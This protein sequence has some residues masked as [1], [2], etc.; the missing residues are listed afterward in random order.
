M[1]PPGAIEAAVAPVQ[2]G[3]SMSAPSAQQD[4]VSRV[5][6]ALDGAPAS[7]DELEP[8][9]LRFEG[10]TLDAGG[11]T[12]R[13]VSGEEIALTRAEFA[14]LLALVRQPGR[15]LSRDE[16]S[17]AAVG[18]GTEPEDRSVDVLVSRLRR[19]IES[20]PKTPRIILTVPGGGYKLGVRSQS[21]ATPPPLALDASQVAASVIA[22]A[23]P[24]AG[25]GWEGRSPA[26]APPELPVPHGR[27]FRMTRTVAAATTLAVLGSIAGLVIA[28]RSTGPTM[29]DTAASA[30]AQKFDP[31][32][33]PLVTDLV[34]AQLSAYAHQPNAKAIALSREG[35][36]ISAG[37]ADDDAARNEAL[38]RCRERDKGGFCRIYAVGE[39]VVWP[40]SSLPLPLPADIRA[41]SPAMPAVTMESVSKTWQTIWHTAP[42]TVA[43]EYL[44]GKGHKALAVALTSSYWSQNRS[45]REEAVRIAI[46]RCSDLARAPCLLISVDGLWTVEMPRSYGLAAPFTLA[47]ESQMSDTERQRVA[48]A[49]NRS[50]WVRRSRF[51]VKW[52]RRMSFRTRM[53]N[54][55]SI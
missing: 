48:Q 46:E 55:I 9:L 31:A 53:E 2:P 43:T 17:H 12:L 22:G 27:S 38:E 13:N 39:D 45:T 16:L 52:P 15:V 50:I 3:V 18:R 24:Q 28:F 19:K 14:M 30:P 21:I 54:Q 33:V 29:R 26:A 6:A 8:S 5:R 11:R 41:D 7:A 34:R 20:A 25:G 40:T 47:G 23:E 4:L 36:G 1:G 10:Y 37:A 42:S 35:W 49:M 44:R 32:A 51:E